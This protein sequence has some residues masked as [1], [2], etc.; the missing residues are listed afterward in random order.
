MISAVYNCY[1]K[2]F[3]LQNLF[4][5]LGLTNDQHGSMFYVRY[6]VDWDLSRKGESKSYYLICSTRNPCHLGFKYLKNPVNGKIMML[7]FEVFWEEWG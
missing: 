6:R 2:G 4:M 5:Y 7:E 3:H 1:V